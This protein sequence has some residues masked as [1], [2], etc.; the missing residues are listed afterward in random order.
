MSHI[1]IEIV[2]PENIGANL[3]GAEKSLPTHY[4]HALPHQIDNLLA[5]LTLWLV[6]I[7][8]QKVNQISLG[9]NPDGIRHGMVIVK[10]HSIT[11]YKWEEKSAVRRQP[12]WFQEGVGSIGST[13]EL[14]CGVRK[15]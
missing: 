13:G 3:P 1:W 12:R 8:V 15:I 2:G 10:D 4:Y 9:G 11:N 5:C 14:S 6:G 7:D